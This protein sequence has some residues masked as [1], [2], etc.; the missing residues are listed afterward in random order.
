MEAVMSKPSALQYAS[1]ELKNDHEFDEQKTYLYIPLPPYPYTL[2]KRK[3]CA[4]Q[5][6]AEELKADE[7]F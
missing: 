6:A 7:H 5:Y 3:G 1:D 4:L 2:V